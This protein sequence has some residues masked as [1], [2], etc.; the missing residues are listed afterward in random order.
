MRPCAAKSESFGVGLREQRI[1]GLRRGDLSLQ[2]APEAEGIR[3]FD[4]TAD[5]TET[6]DLARERADEAQQMRLE[7]MRLLQALD[8]RATADSRVGAET[9][10]LLE[11]I[12]YMGEDE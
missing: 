1:Y 8:L 6:R 7:L 5:P 2:L 9:L 12:G 3:L 4:A 11:D 10:R